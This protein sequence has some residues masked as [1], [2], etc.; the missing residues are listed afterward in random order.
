MEFYSTSQFGEIVYLKANKIK[1][2]RLERDKEDRNKI[3]F[4]FEDSEERAELTKKYYNH[5]GDFPDAMS[6]N[7][8]IRHV[9]SLIHKFLKGQN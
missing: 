4:F 2:D 1:H 8:E 9:K 5:E 3:I 6:F 7:D